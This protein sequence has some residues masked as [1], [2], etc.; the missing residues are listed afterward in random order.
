[1]P[2]KIVSAALT[3]SSVQPFGTRANEQQTEMGWK[4]EQITDPLRN[5]TVTQFSLIGKF[6]TAPSNS[7]SP[8]VMIV[9]CIPGKSM[10]GKT[11][12]K[13]ALGY[14]YVGGVLDTTILGGGIGAVRVSY[15]LDDGK[16]QS[17]AWGRSTNFSAIFMS[18]PG[19]ALCGFANLL[20]GHAMYHKENTSPQVRKVVLGVPE[21]LGGEIVMQFDL[22]DS[23]EV[24]EACGIIMH[25]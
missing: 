24:A 23:A 10:H 8:P 16:V 12:G 19:C 21:Y 3:N 14:I 2:S 7:Q 15:R 5:A 6:L 1:V 4:R 17:E 25:K 22:P 18:Y 13:F 11:N 9:R 20:Y